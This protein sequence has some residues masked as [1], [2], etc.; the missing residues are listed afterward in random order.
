MKDTYFQIIKKPY[1]ISNGKILFFF[2]RQSVK[3]NT[4]KEIRLITA[5]S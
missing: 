3:S 1:F 5:L 2:S 4:T